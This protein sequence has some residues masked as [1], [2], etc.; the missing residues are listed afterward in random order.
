MSSVEHHIFTYN[1]SSSEK[2]K[3]NDHSSPS[4]VTTNTM[5]LNVLFQQ[6]L[7]KISMNFARD[8]LRYMY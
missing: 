3:D 7:D 4:K 8:K 5:I 2:I 6:L 1:V